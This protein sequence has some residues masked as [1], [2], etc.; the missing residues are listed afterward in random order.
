[1]LGLFVGHSMV[2][3]AFQHL[4]AASVEQQ[5]VALL[6]PVAAA[7]LHVVSKI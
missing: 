7:L 6:S 1:M 4:A 2:L 3:L 5:P